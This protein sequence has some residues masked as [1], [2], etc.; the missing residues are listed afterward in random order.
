M[1]ADEKE[2]EAGAKGGGGAG[3]DSVGS[4]ARRQESKEKKPVGAVAL[5]KCTNP[6]CCAEAKANNQLIC[7]VCKVRYVIKTP[8]ERK[9][10]R[11]KKDALGE[12]PYTCDVC[13][14]AT[15]KIGNLTT[16]MR[17]HTGEKPY[18]CDVCDYATAQ[19][20][21]LTRHMRTCQ[22]RA[23]KDAIRYQR[24]MRQ[25]GLS[26]PKEAKAKA[27][28]KGAKGAKGA[29]TR[30]QISIVSGGPSLPLLHASIAANLDVL[31]LS[32]F[33]VR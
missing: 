33:V 8:G 5:K 23:K 10:E 26:R 29:K 9:E 4:K 19:S 11:A 20:C 3:G 7:H 30:K 2:E 32:Y 21:N 18:T 13:D 22:E 14:Y 24:K 28:A 27:K 6:A 12:K 15:E 31:R 25:K 1:V 17:T 16:H